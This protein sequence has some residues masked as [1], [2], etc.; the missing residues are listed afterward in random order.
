MT[1]TRVKSSGIQSSPEFTTAILHSPQFTG[2]SS[3]SGIPKA[4]LSLSDVDNTADTA[5][6]VS[7]AQQTAL[8]LKANLAS[9]TFTGTVTVSGGQIAF[10]ATPLVSANANTLDD[11][12]E[13][14]WSVVIRA[15]TTNPTV[16]YTSGANFGIYVKVGKTVFITGTLAVATMSAA[17]SG[18]LFIPGLPFAASA[19]DAGGYGGFSLGVRSGWTTTAPGVINSYPALSRLVLYG[20]D[21]ATQLTQANLSAAS[22]VQ[23][24]GFY[25]TDL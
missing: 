2:T 15:T 6:P 22:Y 10:P 11:Y 23:F 12:E 17:G 4:L 13:G 3:G 5:K 8:D 7:T 21:F 18:T 19:A 16:T 20:T 9:P 14:T 25:T 24:C 1:R